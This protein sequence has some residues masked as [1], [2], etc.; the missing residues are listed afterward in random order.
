MCEVSSKAGQVTEAAQDRE[1]RQTREEATQRA[2]A[3]ILRL[4]G[5]PKPRTAAEL[6]RWLDMC[7]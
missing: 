5:A 2:E 3:D 7:G 1:V 6:Q 4:P